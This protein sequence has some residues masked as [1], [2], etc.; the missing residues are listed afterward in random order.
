MAIV[1]A[2]LAMGLVTLQ[3]RPRLPWLLPSAV[4]SLLD[5]T[6][7]R[8]DAEPKPAPDGILLALARLGIAP[9]EAV[10]VGDIDSD[11]TAALAAGVTPMGAGWGYAGPPALVSAGAAVVL[12][13]PDRGRARLCSRHHP[14][15]DTAHCDGRQTL[16]DHELVPLQSVVRQSRT[17][18]SQ[19][20]AAPP[21]SDGSGV[22]VF[23]VGARAI[24]VELE[25]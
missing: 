10:F 3:A 21:V 25:N 2:G 18:L 20:S 23:T 11:I 17:S 22:M 7:C 4:L 13:D 5:A 1:D 12:H 14:H 8:E 6:V 15:G 9:F 24:C 16:S 19:W